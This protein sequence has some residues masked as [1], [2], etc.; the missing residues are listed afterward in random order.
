MRPFFPL[1]KGPKIA[2]LWVRVLRDN[3][4]VELSGLDEVPIPVDV[5]V[6]RAALCTGA[7]RGSFSGATAAIFE[8]VRGL[9]RDATRGLSLP[10]G[11]PMVALDLDEALWTLSRLGCSK[12]GNGPVGHCPPDCPAAPGCV[13]GTILTQPGR[14]TVTT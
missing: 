8:Q 6:L 11:R 9:W 3:A 13:A 7:L 10:D 1:L 4:G 14:C 2:P 12:R 5:H